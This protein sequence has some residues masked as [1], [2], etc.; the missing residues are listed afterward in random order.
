M[1]SNNEPQ[2]TTPSTPGFTSPPASVDNSRQRRPQPSRKESQT[3]EFYSS[4]TPSAH[5]MPDRQNLPS[6]SST[7]GSTP[8][9]D[10]GA[11]N[12][13]YTQARSEDLSHTSISP[14]YSYN[15]T[16]GS[17]PGS[18]AALASS[19]PTSP[20]SSGQPSNQPVVSDD[21]AS[22]T[23]FSSAHSGSSNHSRSGVLPSNASTSASLAS[24]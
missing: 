4:S 21:R 11:A 14:G 9:P 17:A 5:R 6:R 15:N 19:R 3:A 18:S 16:S 8:D 10:R 2:S 13:L 1:W 12:N 7:T 20:G 22:V 23:S 24:T